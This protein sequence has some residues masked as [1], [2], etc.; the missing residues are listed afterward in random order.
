M[1]S[2]NQLI[3]MHD[4][5]IV[6]FKGKSQVF[7]RSSI[8]NIELNRKK[9]IIPLVVGGIGTSMAIIAMSM[10][11]YHRTLNLLTIFFFF[12]IMYYGFI[13]KD[14]LEVFEKGNSSVFLLPKITRPL[15]DFKNFFLANNSLSHYSK[16]NFIYHLA[17]PK[18][19]ESQLQSLNYQADSLKNEG[20]IHASFE[21][22]IRE[23]YQKYYSDMQ[24]MVL[25][26]IA[27]DFVEPELKYEFNS[28]RK[29]S[30]PHIYGKLNKTAI[31]RLQ[32]YGVNQ[33][34]DLELGEPNKS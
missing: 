5:L 34:S 11:W 15:V 24:S 12:G 6:L 9:L 27:V 17:R 18:D 21:E 2:K 4:R 7:L 14:A 26:T 28:T 1:D 13:G 31:A 20:F 10:G 32:Y 23:T 29:A 3:L 19:W 8:L 25:I 30:F 16:Q 33:N 22:Q